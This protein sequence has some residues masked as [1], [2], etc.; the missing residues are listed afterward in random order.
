MAAALVYHQAAI[1]L[2]QHQSEFSSASKELLNRFE[3]RSGIR[4]PAAVREWYELEGAVELLAAYSNDDHPVPIESFGEGG[5]EQLRTGVSDGSTLRR[6][7]MLHENQGVCRWAVLLN[8]SDDPPVE[9]E[10]E[11]TASKPTWQHHADSFSA[12]IYTRIADHRWLSDIENACALG[13]QYQRSVPVVVTC[14]RTMME[15]GPRTYA[16]PGK[17][18]YRFL[19]EDRTLLIWDQE[20]G[21]S[22]WWLS[23]DSLESLTDLVSQI[24]GCGGLQSTLY[25]LSECGAAALSQVRNRVS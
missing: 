24:S 7:V 13:A 15:E 19:T 1:D 8:G 5:N 18:N 22:D 16:W 11:F 23:A 17:T 20:N 6:L 2:I 25:D 4:L 9:V 10:I 3:E 21:Q 12:W 14:L